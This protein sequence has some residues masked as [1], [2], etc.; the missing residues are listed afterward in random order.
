MAINPRL[1]CIVYNMTLLY[2]K[3]SI[4]LC[5]KKLYKLIPRSIAPLNS[6][7]TM[8]DHGSCVGLCGF[9][10]RKFVNRASDKD[11]HMIL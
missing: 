1:N 5:V 2:A 8:S 4:D 9:E 10:S 11:K 7:D 3:A 6:S